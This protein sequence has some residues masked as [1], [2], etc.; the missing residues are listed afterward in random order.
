M[1]RHPRNSRARAGG[2]QHVAPLLALLF[3]GGQFLGTAHLLLVPHAVCPEHGELIHID[4]AAVSGLRGA[5]RHETLASAYRSAAE[6]TAVDVHDHCLVSA[7]RREQSAL[8]KARGTLVPVWVSL[9]IAY[10]EH[11]VALPK[12]GAVLLFAPKSSPPAFCA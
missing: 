4:D 2:I 7:L 6:P 3:L 9:P 8:R 10:V 11:A 12:P 1:P 5:A